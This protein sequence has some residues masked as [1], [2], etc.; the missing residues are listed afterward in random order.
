M[1]TITIPSQELFDERNETYINVKERTLKLEHSLVSVRKWEAKY[2]KPFLNDKEKSLKELIS[3]IFYMILNEDVDEN[4]LRFIPKE[5]MARIVEY[6][7]D[8]MTAT[9][10]SDNSTIGA[11][12][13]TR[14]VITAEIIYYWMVSFNIPVEFENWHLNQ[15]LTLIKVISIK[16]DNGG[17]KKL[18][19]REAAAQRMALNAKRRAKYKTKG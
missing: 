15:L 7:K 3:Y 9:W 2:H 5:E 12:K 17:R 13:S 10:F 18:G 16:N 14:D 11:S 19:K 8:P 1:I 6:I 4:I